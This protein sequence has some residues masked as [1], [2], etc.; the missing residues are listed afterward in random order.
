MQNRIYVVGG[1]AGMWRSFRNLGVP[2][3]AGWIDRDY[4]WCG[5]N[6]FNEIAESTACIAYGTLD[7]HG[8]LAFGAAIGYGMPVYAVDAG[9]DVPG[10]A[11]GSRLPAASTYRFWN[12]HATTDNVFQRDTKEPDPTYK[13]GYCE[14]Y[15]QTG[16]RLTLDKA[17][18]LATKR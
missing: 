12:L 17:I 3:V 15:L 16:N 14:R 18:E 7:P 10:E 13:D 9:I 5:C 6:D 11:P 8:V 4:E 1:A 2:I